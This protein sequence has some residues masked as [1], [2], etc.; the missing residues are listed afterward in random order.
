MKRLNNM[1][2][3]KT[4]L[5]FPFII[6]VIIGII[7][8]IISAAA[9]AFIMWI[10][11]FPVEWGGFLGLLSLAWGCYISGYILGKNKRH[12]GIKQGLLCGFAM[13]IFSV[14][15]GVVISQNIFGGL[16]AKI[17]VC[18]VTGVLGGVFGVNSGG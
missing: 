3:L 11:Q 14:A 7:V 16:G 6:S 8:C 4:H 12:Q 15:L 5:V 10:F 2:S 17:V 18:L 1:R 13:L 9:N